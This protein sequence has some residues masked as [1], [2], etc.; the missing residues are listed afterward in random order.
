MFPANCENEVKKFCLVMMQNSAKMG[1]KIMT[2]TIVKLDNDRPETYTAAIRKAVKPGQQLIMTVCPQQRGDRY[3]AIKKLCCIEAPIANQCILL[4]TIKD[5]RKLASVAQKVILQMNCKL[6]GELWAALIPVKTLMVIGMD[7]WH[8]KGTKSIAGVVASFN[9]AL[10]RYYSETAEQPAQGHESFSYLRSAVRHAFIKYHEANNRTFPEHVIIFRDGVGDGQL[11]NVENTEA[12]PLIAHIYEM[13]KELN[14]RN[15]KKQEK[16]DKT[17]KSDAQEVTTSSSSSGD[18]D[19]TR[20]EFAPSINDE[21]IKVPSVS[22]VVVQKRINTRI[23]K[24]NAGSDDFENP[25]PGTIVDS[26]VTRRNFKDFFLVPQ[27]VN[28]GTV[29][30]THFVVIKEMGNHLKPDQIQKLAYKLTH[31]YF[32]WP[33]TVRVPAP[34]QYAHKLVDLVGENIHEQVRSKALTQR[35]FYL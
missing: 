1:I 21:P 14:D 29:T 35:L 13:V 9:P 19:S 26:V 27:S 8:G 16:K 5:E 12:N 10:T 4:K 34:C 17:D 7:V 11:M 2:P 15:K 30:P 25:P 33:G 28:Q 31:M 18:T 20:S 22:F 24:P 6:G 32:N 23:Y 3:S